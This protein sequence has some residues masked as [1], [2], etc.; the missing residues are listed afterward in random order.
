MRTVVDTNVV[1]SAALFPERTPGKA[2]KRA[3]QRGVALLSL[4]LAEELRRVFRRAKFD[5]YVAPVLRDEF[6]STLID[7]H[8]AST[9]GTILD[10]RRESGV[11]WSC[12]DGLRATCQ[13]IPEL[14]IQAE[15][16]DSERA[17]AFPTAAP[18]HKNAHTAW[19][20]AKRDVLAVP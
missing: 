10:Y 8:C 5:R 2:F 13:H 11:A 7:P 19:L 4:P 12:T 20:G 14:D 17:A 18:S 3:R 6:L 16:P 9:L 1:V 15:R